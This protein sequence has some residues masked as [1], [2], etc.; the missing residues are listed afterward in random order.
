MFST[1]LCRESD[2]FEDDDEIGRSNECR[3]MLL[4]AGSDPLRGGKA[5]FLGIMATHNPNGVS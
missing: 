4:S 1:A 3:E 5:S 2:V